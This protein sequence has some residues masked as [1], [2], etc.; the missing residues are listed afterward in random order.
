M[1]GRLSDCSF[2]LLIGSYGTAQYPL[3]NKGIDLQP[4]CGLQ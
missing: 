3:Q 2:I 4:T 1:I